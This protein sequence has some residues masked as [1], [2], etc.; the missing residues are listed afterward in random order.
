MLDS[1]A[2]PAQVDEDEKRREVETEKEVERLMHEARMWRAANSAQWVAWGTVQ[3]MVPGMPDRDG[4]KQKQGEGEECEV[5]PE[6]T[7]G[8][9]PNRG[10]DP[11]TNENE[12]LVQDAHDKRPE[13]RQDDDEGD[14]FDYLSYAQERAMLFW[15]DALALGVVKNEDLPAEMLQKVKIVNY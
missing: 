8:Q 10:S 11:V 3:A 4:S 7:P 15:G 9:S 13:E 12:G 14:E 1:R 2:P 5:D 6:K